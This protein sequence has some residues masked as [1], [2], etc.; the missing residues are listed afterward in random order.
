MA[1]A[2]FQ[3]SRWGSGMDAARRGQ[4]DELVSKLGMGELAL[5]AFDLVGA[6]ASE[7]SL[8]LGSRDTCGTNRALDVDEGSASRGTTLSNGHRLLFGCHGLVFF[9]HCQRSSS[10]CYLVVFWVQKLGK[11]P[12][13]RTSRGWVLE[14]V[15]FVSL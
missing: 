2:R 8:V 4:T 11:G 5:N 13:T 3:A 7:G 15:R 10:R 6:K 14:A 12:R 1:W 9:G